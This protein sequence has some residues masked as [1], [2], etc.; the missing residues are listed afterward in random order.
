MRKG[1]S[2]II[3]F[4]DEKRILL[5]HRSE[6]AERLPGYWGFFGGG[7]ENNETS[8]QAVRRESFEELN[9]VPQNPKLLMVQNF[10][11]IGHNVT[12]YVFLEDEKNIDKTS[13]RLQE[14]QGWGWFKILETKGLK[15]VEHDREVLEY[16][17]DKL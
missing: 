16:I 2:V 17:K 14:G 3:L 12:K 11:Y 9:Y 1:V 8:E 4:D 10:Q 13:L 5:Q 15:M 6:D 7:I